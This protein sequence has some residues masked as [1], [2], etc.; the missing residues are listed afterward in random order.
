MLSTLNVLHCP[1]S[2]WTTLSI[3]II[4]D[5][6]IRDTCCITI[7]T[8]SISGLRTSYGL[9]LQYEPRQTIQNKTGLN[10]ICLF[11]RDYIFNIS[12]RE[13]LSHVILSG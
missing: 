7:F 4:F 2:L 12:T 3:V 9:D 11:N 13:F 1:N 6:G 5:L 10:K 8:K